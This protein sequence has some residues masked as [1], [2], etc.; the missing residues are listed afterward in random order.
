MKASTPALV[1][2]LAFGT[3]CGGS[4]AAP[5]DQMKTTPVTVYRLQNYEPPQQTTAAVPG[6][7]GMPAMPA[8][9]QKWVSAGASMLPPG[10]IPPGLIPGAT[11]PAAQTM[12]RL[13]TYRVLGYM[14]VSDP[15]T[16][17]DA[18]DIFGKEKN[19]EAPRQACMYPEFGFTFGAPPPL[20]A[21]AAPPPAVLVSLSCNQVQ[22]QNLAWPHGAKTGLTQDTADKITALVKRSFGG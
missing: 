10:L 12:D 8:E 9:I 11:A 5:F 3:G 20:A 18:L 14:A 1:L 21:G 6:I 4:L 7:P 22:A 16:H 19:F 2:M 17:D 15:K 13:Y